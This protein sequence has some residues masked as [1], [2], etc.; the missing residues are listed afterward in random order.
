M[1]VNQ[2][3]LRNRLRA[4]GRAL[5]DIRDERSGI[6]VMYHLT[7][8]AAYE[9]W[10][11]LL[12]TRFLTENNLL[13]T[14]EANSSVPVT[15]EECEEL[16]PELVA[17]DG[18]ELACRFAGLT[19]PGVFRKD[20][21]V[22]DLPIAINDQVELRKLLA[23]L[24][25][26]C[27]RA[28][29]ALWTYQFW[30]AQRKDEVNKSGKKIGANELS[31]VTQLF[32]ED[33]MVEFLLHNTLGAWWAGKIGTIAAATELE[34]RARTGLPA[35]D[36]LPA[37]IWT[38][39]Q[40]VKVEAA[41]C[42]F[43]SVEAASC[44][45]NTETHQNGA[46]TCE[47]KRQD[48]ASTLHVA[49]ARLLG[50]Q[51]PRQTGSSFPD[52]PALGPD[53]LETFADE[54]G[55]VCLPP[56]NRKQPAVAR[57]RQLLN[58]ALG[59]IDE[60][61]L[62][63]AAEPKGSKSKA[64]EDWLRDEFFEQHAKLFHDRPFIWH[65]WD[66]RADGFHALVNYHKLDHATLQKPTYSYL[67]DWIQQQ[68]NDAKADKPGAAERL[69]SACALEKKLAAI[70]EGEAPLD[71]FVRWKPIK[72]QTQGWHPDLHDGVRLNIRPF[73]QAPDVGKKDAGLLRTKP[74]VKWEKDRGKE[75]IR[76]KADYPW[77][78][79]EDEPG[80]DPFGGKEF[81]GNRWND[82]HLTLARK[83]AA[84]N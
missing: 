29:N 26:D 51:W 25:P 82:V 55:I 36:G 42:R 73:L 52:C 13:I 35:R 60:R 10:H 30:Q 46:S 41:S 80:T 68:A 78:W 63:T 12:F 56:L 77:F 45:V 74:D 20:D 59:S 1:I 76:D 81:T 65:I 24:P 48:A 21:P 70:L 38:Y 19:L 16:A 2:R 84:R 39:L 47:E 79:C 54:D 58:A 61:T 4:R 34:A 71:I 14:D 22:L 44:R 57:L 40:F 69:G 31:P 3:K 33:Y 62:I 27:F 50:Y 67:G 83:K 64:L 18:Q 23:S 43:D 15:L 9:H 72:N 49:V 53:G 75:P 32:T 11:R 7:E 28:D 8:L 17:R 6:Q 37:L 5:G 66:G